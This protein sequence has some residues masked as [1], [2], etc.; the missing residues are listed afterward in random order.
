VFSGS[1]DLY[2]RGLQH[3]GLRSLISFDEKIEF[4]STFEMANLGACTPQ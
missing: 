4:V 1:L 2:Q 3:H